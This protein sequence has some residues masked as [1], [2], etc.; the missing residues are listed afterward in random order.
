MRPVAVDPQTIQGLPGALTPE[1]RLSLHRVFNK[2]HD[3]LDHDALC[4]MC[5]G[6]GQGIAI[7]LERV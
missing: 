7:I 5:V 1:D 3:F 6:L 4:T 2:L